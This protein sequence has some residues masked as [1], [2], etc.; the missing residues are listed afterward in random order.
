MPLKRNAHVLSPLTPAEIE[1]RE[2]VRK[3]VQVLAGDIGGRDAVKSENL[4]KAAEY[5]EAQLR[6]FGYGP[7]RQTYAAAGN[8]FDNIEAELKGK[9]EVDRIAVIGAH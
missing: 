7:L 8:S 2:R 9:K 3:M 1:M 6:S 4:R 5:I